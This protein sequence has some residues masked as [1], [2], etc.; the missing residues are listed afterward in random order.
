MSKPNLLEA[1]LRRDRTIVVLALT[2]I[3]GVSWAYILAGAGMG[4]SAFD[5]TSLSV[6]LGETEE[7]PASPGA[8]SQGVDGRMAGVMAAMATPVAWT[9]GYALLMFFMWWV[10][11]IAMMLPS[12]APM[13]LLHAKVD[14]GARA[15]AGEAGRLIPTFTFIFGYLAVWGLF[16][17]L[18]AILQSAFEAAALLSPMTMNATNTLFAGAIL[19]FAGLYQLTPIKQACLRHCR[20]PIQ[21]LSHHWRPGARGA[22]LMGV[23]HG[24]YCL[25]CCPLLRWHH[26][27]LLDRGIGVDRAAGKGDAGRAGLGQGDRW[28]A[29]DM[30]R[31]LSCEGLRLSLCSPQGRPLRTPMRP[32]FPSRAVGAREAV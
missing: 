1:V 11:M 6:A 28:V 7:M 30:G 4:M 23:H 10:M 15:R 13:I 27:P 22:L 25:G 17:A 29:V 14:R 18:A 31:R 3:I 9:P 5:M 20:G 2:L 24:A 12:A 16:S 26:E 19:L 8:S 21:F 32:L